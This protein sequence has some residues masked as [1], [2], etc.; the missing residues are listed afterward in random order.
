MIKAKATIK[1]KGNREVYEI[2]I[3]ICP[4]HSKGCGN[5]TFQFVV[6]HNIDEDYKRRFGVSM[7]REIS[8]DIEQ[9]ENLT[10]EFIQAIE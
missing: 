1:S 6:H 9:T 8:L 3:E 7:P 5:R 10:N 2:T 4:I